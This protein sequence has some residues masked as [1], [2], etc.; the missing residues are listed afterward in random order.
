MAITG[1]TYNPGTQGAAWVNEVWANTIDREAYNL[2][3]IR[4]LILKQP[5]LH[6]KLHIPKHAALSPSTIADTVDM[7]GHGLTFSANTEVEFTKTPHTVS[8]NVSVNDNQIGRM[9]VDPKD[10][11][12]T[13]I[14]SALAQNVDQAIATLFA[15]LTTNIS[16]SYAAPL[17]LSTILEAK[18]KCRVGAK[19]YAD[20]GQMNF[21]YS[22]T[23]ED[24]VLS[25]GNFVQAYV[26]GD[27]ENPA[28][29]GK[30]IEAYGLRFVC[31]GNVQNS[32]GGY[33]NCVFI[34]R[35][36]VISFNQEPTVEAQRFGLATWLLGWS[37]F[38]TDTLRD[39]YAAL[40][41]SN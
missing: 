5:A 29:G 25:I 8:L 24:S 23:Q 4:P 27:N 20:D 2:A 21:V 26:R 7:S 34:Q 15:A 28:V 32:G 10:T 17:D 38:G 13:S 19:E 22:D 1:N 30:I 14:T 12:R 39:G 9:M 18:S 41:K 37:D 11:L 36:F 31:T 33:N 40:A 6:K 16:G 3:K 35:A